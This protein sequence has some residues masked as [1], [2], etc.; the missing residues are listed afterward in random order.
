M[1]LNMSASVML[2]MHMSTLATTELFGAPALWSDQKISIDRHSDTERSVQLA[3]GLLHVPGTHHLYKGMVTVQMEKDG[4]GHWHATN[5]F[6]HCSH[7][8]TG[9]WDEQRQETFVGDTPGIDPVTAYTCREHEVDDPRYG[10]KGLLP[11][12]STKFEFSE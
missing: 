12:I 11:R 6:V 10:F 8:R 9:Q 4:A 7:P 5:V 1:S 3:G 2:A